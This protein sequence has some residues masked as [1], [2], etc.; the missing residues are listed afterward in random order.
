MDTI[1]VTYSEYGDTKTF[2]VVHDRDCMPTETLK[3]W[4]SITTA[5][6]Q[7]RGDRSERFW[8]FYESMRWVENLGFRL[9]IDFGDYFYETGMLSPE[10][11]DYAQG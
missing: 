8:H 2:K 7:I 9:C 11:K 10:I 5:N 6:M 1:Y 3:I 4:E